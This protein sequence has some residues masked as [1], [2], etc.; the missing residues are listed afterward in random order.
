MKHPENSVHLV[1]QILIQQQQQQQTTTKN[2]QAFSLP[3]MV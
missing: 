2:Q 3:S 1:S